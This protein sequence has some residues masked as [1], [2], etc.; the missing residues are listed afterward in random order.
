MKSMRGVWWCF[1]AIFFANTF[2]KLKKSSSRKTSSLSKQEVVYV[3]VH[4]HGIACT[5]QTLQCNNQAN[6]LSLK[7]TEIEV[8]IDFRSN[9]VH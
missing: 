3:C 4:S 1:N 8:T 7:I 5:K 2:P 6:E 9:F